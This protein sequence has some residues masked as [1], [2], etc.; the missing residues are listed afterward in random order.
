MTGRRAAPVRDWHLVVFLVIL[1]FLASLFAGSLY[2]FVL[3]P[4]LRGSET[5]VVDE[6]SNS[7]QC[8]SQLSEFFGEGSWTIR[9]VDG[10]LLVL[11][12]KGRWFLVYEL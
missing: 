10:K 3:R 11:V 2:H 5:F 6:T 4:Y 9:R 7:D 1:V 8:R 12:C